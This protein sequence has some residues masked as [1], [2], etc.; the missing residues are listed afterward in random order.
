M[1]QTWQGISGEDGDWDRPAP[2]EVSWDSE[3]KILTVTRLG[4]D[5]ARVG[6]ENWSL[7][8]NQAA[9]L[10]GSACLDAAGVPDAKVR[11]LVIG[12][13]AGEIPGVDVMEARSVVFVADSAS[14]AKQLFSILQE[15]KQRGLAVLLQN[16]PGVLARAIVDYAI[17]QE[18]CDDSEHGNS[19]AKL[20][21]LG[22]IVSVPGERQSGIT[23]DARFEDIHSAQQ[24]EDLVRFSN[25]NVK[26]VSTDLGFRVTV[27]PP[28]KFCFSHIEWL[29]CSC[30]MPKPC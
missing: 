14:A 9:A 20:P 30:D 18:N 13:H 11:A 8:R 16:V 27:D 15:A 26:I 6:A 22:V 24:A 28:M 5:E 7:V 4:Y 25:P 10:I 2:Y 29:R 23:M 17:Y 1:L 19:A 21:A 12:R 3:D